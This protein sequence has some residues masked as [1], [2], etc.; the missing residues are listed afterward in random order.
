MQRTNN[1]L[2]SFNRFRLDSLDQGDLVEEEYDHERRILWRSHAVVGLDLQPL[3][4][5]APRDPAENSLEAPIGSLAEYFLLFRVRYDHMT[6][7]CCDKRRTIT[8]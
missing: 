6:E 8:L 4:V 7:I 3:H 2:Y 1:S 5:A